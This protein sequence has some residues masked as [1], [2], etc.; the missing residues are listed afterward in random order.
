MWKLCTRHHSIY[1]Q[2]RWSGPA[3]CTSCSSSS[4]CIFKTFVIASMSSRCC[5]PIIELTCTG[6]ADFKQSGLRR[7][8]EGGAHHEGSGMAQT[9]GDSVEYL[10]A[11]PMD[12]QGVCYEKALRVWDD[13]SRSNPI[14]GLSVYQTLFQVVWPSHL[15]VHPVSDRNSQRSRWASNERWQCAQN[16]AV[17]R[18]GVW[19]CFLKPL[20]FHHAG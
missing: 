8:T 14:F 9:T 19:L 10:K 2:G 6:K 15:K 20:P 3:I 16:P 11:P 7:G 12:F 18:M 17:L 5:R 4:L 13:W 1:L